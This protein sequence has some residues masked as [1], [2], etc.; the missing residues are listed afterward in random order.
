MEARP[1]NNEFGM[2]K[3]ARLNYASLEADCVS[4]ACNVF[5]GEDSVA[6]HRKNVSLNT[7]IFIKI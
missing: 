5:L 3:S 1:L 4:A 7:W 2:L 6:Y